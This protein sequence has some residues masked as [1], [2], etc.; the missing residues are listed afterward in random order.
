MM[1]NEN[2][3]YTTIIGNYDN[4]PKLRV[5]KEENWDYICFTDNKDLKSDVWEIV[6]VENNG[7]SQLENSRLSRYFKT[8]YY[9]YLSSYTTILYVDARIKI[10]GNINN[11][12]KYLTGYD[13]V[14]NK[15]PEA[16]NIEEEMGRVL[17]GKLEKKEVI[18]KIKKR[19]EDFNYKYD[20]GLFVGGFLLYKNNEKT[21]KF[22]K[23][24]W[25]EIKNYSYRD[26]LS[27]NFVL[28]NNS[29]LKYKV[30]NYNN[31]RSKYFKQE[32]RK[33]KRLTFN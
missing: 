17:K 19:Y 22:F 28:K 5:K 18:D 27:L 33:N 1:K 21:L 23:E 16:N 6:Y 25:Y 14:F 3:I 2:C 11:Y 10:V 7:N 31:T 26:Q 8:N 9:N 20:N 13:I 32:P 30:I 29:A 12:L 24:W 15:H 4:I